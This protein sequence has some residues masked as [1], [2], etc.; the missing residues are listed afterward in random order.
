MRLKGDDLGKVLCDNCHQPL[1]S[2]RNGLVENIHC[3]I[4]GYN[5]EGAL[6]SVSSRFKSRAVQAVAIQQLEDAQCFFHLGKKAVAICASCG[7]MLCALCDIE[8]SN[9]HVC[10]RCIN[11][12]KQSGAIL[13]QRRSL[14]Y[15]QV[16]WSCLLLNFII[17]VIPAIIALVF[18]VCG[19]KNKY[20]CYSTKRKLSLILALICSI[21][22]ICFIPVAIVLAVFA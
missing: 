7:R 5:C 22:A 18:A 10:P 14:A 4:C 21:P 12:R 11:E 20:Y 13:K 17:P 8:Q 19:L 1:S 6:F 9:G 2:V 15:M 3:R 16:A